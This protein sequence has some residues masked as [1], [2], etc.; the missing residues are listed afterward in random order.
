MRRVRSPAMG[1]PL[2]RAG[3]ERVWSG[4]WVPTIDRRRIRDSPSI[5]SMSTIVSFCILIARGWE[6]GRASCR[7][8]GEI[9]GGGVSLKKKKKNL[10]ARRSL[11]MHEED[12]GQQWTGRG[13]WDERWR[14]CNREGCRSQK[15][16][17]EESLIRTRK[18]LEACE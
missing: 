9:S 12:Q 14:K 6:I 17:Y 4:Y 7:E 13:R 1:W 5:S 11:N 3:W 10:R 8:R 2:R 18:C 16:A 15:R